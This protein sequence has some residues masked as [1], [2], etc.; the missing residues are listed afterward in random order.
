MVVFLDKFTGIVAGMSLGRTATPADSELVTALFE[1]IG[2]IHVVDEKLLN[3]VT[4]V[5]Y[6]CSPG[7]TANH[8]SSVLSAVVSECS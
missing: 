5:R 8:E 2:K 1:S 7:F 4:G 3:A 6:R